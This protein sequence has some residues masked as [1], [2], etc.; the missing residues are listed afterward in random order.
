MIDWDHSPFTSTRLTV[1]ST[2]PVPVPTG[3]VYPNGQPI[4]RIEYPAPIGFLHFPN[5]EKRYETKE[6]RG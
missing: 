4:Y 2:G 6:D 3:L 5:R 1:D